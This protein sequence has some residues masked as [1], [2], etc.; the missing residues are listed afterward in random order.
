[1][2]ARRRLLAIV[3][4]VAVGSCSPPA[5]IEALTVRVLFGPG[6]LG[7][8]STN[9]SVNAGI[10]SA[11]VSTS[12]DVE[13][14][15]PESDE[16]AAAKL[17]EW[18]ERSGPR[19]LIV[20]GAPSY[21]P[22]VEALECDFN[23]ASILL[24]DAS[25]E[26]CPNLRSVSFRSF[27]PAY[28]GGVAAVSDPS[29]APTGR[30]A[31][32]GG[33]ET[34]P[35]REL[36]DGFRAGV[37]ATGGEVVGELFVSEDPA[38]GFSSPDAAAALADG[39]FGTVDVIFVAAGRS[40][41]GVGELL[42]ERARRAPPGADRVWFVDSDA[43]EILLYGEVT[44]ANVIERIDVVVRD[45]ILEM[46]A[47]DLTSGDVVVGFRDHLTELLLH[48]RRGP[49]VLEGACDDCDVFVPSC[50]RECTTLEN[51]VTR[52]ESAAAEAARTWRSR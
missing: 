22:L 51:V 15:L 45:A 5:R 23:G 16:E 50:Y 39:L 21:A 36:L 6:G 24:V 26:T 17:D 9:D 40:S 44:I 7:N 25:A 31:M 34:P 52:A 4:L 33:A 2:S 28:L 1:M 49:R 8:S 29:L 3:A 37:E 30:V 41:E 19:D 18:L 43:N 32:I 14:F 46:I 12:F 35:V 42:E 38:E 47:G 13:R 10:L 11:R 27:A 20:L 48:P